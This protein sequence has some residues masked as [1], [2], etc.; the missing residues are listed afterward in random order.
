MKYDIFDPMDSIRFGWNCLKANIRFFVFLMIIAAALY[1]LPFLLQIMLIGFSGRSGISSGGGI[2]FLA[3]LLPV[4][5]LLIYLMVDLGLLKIALSFRDSKN[6][7]IEDIFRGYPRLLTY[8]AASVLF[9]LMIFVPPFLLSLSGVFFM[10][11]PFLGM[12]LS[13][14][15]MILI[16]VVVIYLFIKYQF[17]GY[18]IVDKNL[19]AIEAL[20]ESAKLTKGAEKNLLVFWLELYCGFAVILLFFVILIIAPLTILAGVLSEKL[21]ASFSIAMNLVVTMINLIVIVPI[22]KLATADVY[23]RLEGRSAAADGL[24]LS[25][26][27]V[28]VGEVQQVGGT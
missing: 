4:L 7:E 10:M 13:L 14:I 25:D 20:K 22:I 3:I 21:L 15:L 26:S 23:R 9:F 12:I 11:D 2:L 16:L 5:S 17:Y 8:L 24:D 6:P 19:G 28:Q 27:G 18:L 1:V